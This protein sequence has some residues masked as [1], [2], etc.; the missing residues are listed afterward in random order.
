MK[1]KFLSLAI[2]VLCFSTALAVFSACGN[3]GGTKKPDKNSSSSSFSPTADSEI[4]S[5]TSSQNASSDPFVSWDSYSSSA[6]DP[7]ESS[8]IEQSQSVEDSSS[9]SV[10]ESSSQSVEESSSQSVEESSSQSVEESSSQSAEESSSQSVEESSSQSVEESSSSS[11][12][13]QSS[14][15][16]EPDPET[17]PEPDPTPEGLEGFYYVETPL[18]YEITGVKDTSET[19]LTITSAAKSI[20]DN[21]FSE[22][23]DLETIIIDKSVTSIGDGAFEGCEK[24]TAI[25]YGGNATRWKR[26]TLG[27]NNSIIPEIVCYYYANTPVNDERDWHY[28]ADGNVV[29]WPPRKSTF[30]SKMYSMILKGEDYVLTNEY[31]YSYFENASTVF[32]YE[33]ARY[34]FAA[35]AAN[36][37]RSAIKDFFDT[38]GY[39]SADAVYFN[40]DAPTTK[41]QAAYAISHKRSYGNDVILLSFR[42]FVYGAEEFSGNFDLSS[43]GNGKFHSSFYICAQAAKTSLDAYIT[44]GGYDPSR[45]KILITGYSRGGAIA[46][47]LGCLLNTQADYT[48]ENLFV[49]TFEAP[50]TAIGRGNG[51]KNIYNII[52]REDFVTYSVP[53]QFGFARAG[54]DVD[55][56]DTSV[57]SLVKAFDSKLSVPTFTSAS[58][59][60]GRSLYTSFLSALTEKHSS[61]L[62]SVSTVSEYEL[63]L[64]EALEATFKKLLSMEEKK[65]NKFISHFSANGQSTFTSLLYDGSALY[66]EAKAAFIYA[67]ESY[68]DTALQKECTRLTKVLRGFLYGNITT[69]SGM[70]QSIADNVNYIIYMHTEETIYSLLVAYG[71]KL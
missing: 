26:V 49:Y 50:R 15:D 4:S 47:V 20:G 5:E 57:A 21:A 11:E 10:E 65:R 52:S 34:A 43:D 6:T 45:V 54:T 51:D 46:N 2:I 64:R 25:Y 71:D 66:D 3:G 41:N 48:K 38:A 31:S 30:K 28:D 23:A 61:F 13:G 70:L 62:T 60:N 63:N 37:S 24:L 29:L 22:C 9:Q 17:D 56:Y 59:S 27:D 32:S 18:G 1:K 16:P 36:F 40:Y 68:D 67:G 7:S 14:S 19:H 44:N 33:M 12:S 42:G 53:S 55:I 39:V 8:S 58:Y 35:A 69:A